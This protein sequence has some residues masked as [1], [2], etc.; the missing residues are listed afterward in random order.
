MKTLKLALLLPMVLLLAGWSGKTP[1]ETVQVVFAELCA[2]GDP[3]A[4]RP[5]LANPEEFDELKSL[6]DI[7][8]DVDPAKWEQIKSDTRADC[9]ANRVVEF[10]R[11]D[12]QGDKATV[13]FLQAN[14]EEGEDELLRR[15][16]KWKLV[17]AL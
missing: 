13:R 11:V 9:A 6:V 17:V 12:I 8:I 15:D 2:S 7:L 10:R 3:L 4:M 1:E 16:G 5:Y 14:G